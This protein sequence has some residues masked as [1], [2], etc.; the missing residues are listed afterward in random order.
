MVIRDEETGTLWQ[1]ATGEA[2][3]GPLK[4][5][6]LEILNGALLTLGAWKEQHPDSLIALPPEKWTGLVPL[7][8]VKIVLGKAT[9]SGVVPGLTPGDQRLVNNTPIVG[10]AYQDI[11]RAYPMKLLEQQGTIQDQFGD[12]LITL[13]YDPSSKQVAL[14]SPRR[15]E[16]LF[17]RTWWN[18]WFE[19][20]P[21]TEVYQLSKSEPT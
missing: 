17:R 11:A 2:V 13:K 14:D 10:L 9:G 19:F 20:Y 15:D 18:G 6:Q 1:H 21:E 5:Q 4:G 16:I 7:D 3:A 8:K 12:I